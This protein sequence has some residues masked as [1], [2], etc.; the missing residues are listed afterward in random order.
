MLSYLCVLIFDPKP[1][2]CDR[3]ENLNSKFKLK[4]AQRMRTLELS[5][6]QTAGQELALI[7]ILTGSNGVHPCIMLLHSLKY[8][9]AIMVLIWFLRRNLRPL[10]LQNATSSPC[11][12]WQSGPHFSIRLP[13]SHHLGAGT[14]NARGCSHM[15]WFVIKMITSSPITHICCL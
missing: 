13:P 4:L 3:A 11:A 2:F 10:Q 15:T 6:L 1:Y 8:V 7:L 14:R 12:P 5:V 9:P